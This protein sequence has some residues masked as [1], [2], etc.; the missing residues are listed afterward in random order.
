[1]DDWEKAYEEDRR[2]LAL[3]QGIIVDGR[4]AGSGA[5]GGGVGGGGS[6]VEMNPFE[7]KQLEQQAAATPIPPIAEAPSVHAMHGLSPAMFE[8]ST[9][10]RD[11]AAPHTAAQREGEADV[12]EIYAA[13]KDDPVPRRR[14]M[15][16][17]DAG[18][19]AASA[20]AALHDARFGLH[21]LGT[22]W[23]L[24]TLFSAKLGRRLFF[25]EVVK[26][27]FKGFLSTKDA[28]VGC[29]VTPNCIYIGDVE[30]AAL[31]V[32]VDIQWLLEVYAFDGVAVGLRT[33]DALELHLQTAQH[34]QRLVDILQKIVAHWQAK[35]KFIQATAEREKTFRKEMRLIDKKSHTWQVVE[36]P[37][38]GLRI[39][40]ITDQFIGILAPIAPKILHWFGWVQQPRKDWKG[41]RTL[42]RRCAWATA[43]CFFVAKAEGPGS[44]G[45]GIRH[46]V[47]MQYMTELYVG[48]GGEL[49]I[50]A[51]KGPPQ[52]PTVVVLDSEGGKNALIFIF[53]ECYSYRNGGGTIKVTHVKSV[54]DAARRANGSGAS[55]PQLF[56]M[57]PRRELYDFLRGPSAKK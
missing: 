30:T 6:S 41:S 1:M 4:R 12:A 13:Y 40:N 8:S 57:R 14:G 56:L 23:N 47:A 51:A 43:T 49:G 28:V 17:D 46:C 32:C 37:R 25:A 34:T 53:Q 54:E 7:E 2:R 15:D 5:G 33:K 3:G 48:P 18:D 31:V 50:V 19:N 16:D 45:H 20:G 52:P 44:D 36:D 22:G 29:F 39:L 26:T 38:T 55:R 21:C 11:D 35:V 27:S 10:K 42:Q 24:H 9:V